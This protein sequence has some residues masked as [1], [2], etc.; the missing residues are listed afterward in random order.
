MFTAVNQVANYRCLSKDLPGY[1]RVGF[2]N[3]DINLVTIK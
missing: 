1:P 3:D 2:L